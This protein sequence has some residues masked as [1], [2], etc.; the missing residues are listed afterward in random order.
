LFVIEGASS[1]AFAFRK[2]KGMICGQA[3]SGQGSQYLIIRRLEGKKFF[4]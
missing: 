1:F 3:G 2:G 4:E